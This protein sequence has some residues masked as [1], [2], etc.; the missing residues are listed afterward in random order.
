M[1]L[2][3]HIFALV[4]L[5]A[6]QIANAA[7]RVTAEQLEAILDPA[8]VPKQHVYTASALA[9]EDAYSAQLGANLALTSQDRFS[10]DVGY[11]GGSQSNVSTET[12]RGGV[13]YDHDFRPVG[14]ELG[15]QYWGDQDRI[16]SHGF[17]GTLYVHGEVGRAAFVY[18]RRNIELKFDVPAGARGFVDNS[19]STDSNGYG[20]SLR[21][22][23][24]HADFY[25]TGMDYDYDV[26]LTRLAQLINLSRLSSTQRTEFLTRIGAF[27]TNLS[28]L[29]ASSLSLASTLLDYNVAVGADIPIGR[30]S[31]N[32][33]LAR[34][35]AATDGVTLDSAS[36][37]LLHSLRSGIDIEY[38]IGATKGDEVESSAFGGITL[39]WY[40]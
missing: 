21:V 35:V 24:D 31:L 28:R 7:D 39:F 14:F 18:E 37:G 6:V 25:A 9:S 20:L 8:I 38:R 12:F 30:T 10:F 19:R 22:N 29:N 34:D 23:T 1:K 5:I 16:A 4:F 11:G 15:Y 33:E 2:Y 27:L 3:K 36:I 13:A 26:D 40:H 32:L 17:R